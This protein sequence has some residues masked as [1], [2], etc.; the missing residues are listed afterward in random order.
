MAARKEIN[1][2]ERG[3]LILNEAAQ[4]RFRDIS[5]H[6]EHEIGVV[7]GESF[8]LADLDRPKVQ[9]FFTEALCMVFDNDM[10]KSSRALSGRLAASKAYVKRELDD[11]KELSE[12]TRHEVLAAYVRVG[13]ILEDVTIGRRA[14]NKMDTVP[15]S[16]RAVSW[17]LEY[18][19]VTEAFFQRYLDGSRYYDSAIVASLRPHYPVI[20]DVFSDLVAATVQGSP[21][22]KQPIPTHRQFTDRL[23]AARTYLPERL[24]ERLPEMRPDQIE[25][26]SL[27]F[28]RWSARLSDYARH[29]TRE[30]QRAHDNGHGR[31]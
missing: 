17:V 1:I 7:M 28:D 13:S 26:L 23:N 27:L 22:C 19:V 20:A 9:R 4:S 21:Q 25:M 6:L 15:L 3:A 18:G 24:H 2:S 29:L 10:P 11:Y 30:D 16:E 12:T 5:L 8:R 14:R 31:G